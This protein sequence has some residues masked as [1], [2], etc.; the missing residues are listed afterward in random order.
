M[1]YNQLLKEL[2]VCTEKEFLH[3]VSTVKVGQDTSQ[4]ILTSCFVMANEDSYI[5]TAISHYFS[6]H[7]PYMTVT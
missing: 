1:E 6:S 3:G 5:N 4:L 2:L 7:E